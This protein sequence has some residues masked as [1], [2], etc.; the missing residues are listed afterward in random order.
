MPDFEDHY[1]ASKGVQTRYWSVGKGGIPIVLL[2]GL[3]G[4]I[5]DWSETL[6]H[7]SMTRRV[8]AIDLLGS[9]KTDKS[10]TDTYTPDVMRDHVLS[11]L[12]ALSLD[13]VDI[14]GWSLGGRI[15]IDVAHAAPHRL[16][17]L[18]LTAPAGIGADTMID[19][20]A[21]L[22]VILGQAITRP[23]ASSVRIIGNAI[24]S[25]SARRLMKFTARRL[26]LFSDPTSRHAFMGQLKSFVGP[27]GFLPGPRRD[28]L[29]KLPLI[30]T[31]TLAAWGR[32]DNFSPF[33]HSAALLDLMP[34]CKLNVVE[35]CGHTPQIEWPQIYNA[36]V[37]KFVS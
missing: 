2:H 15:A 20:N 25:G 34:H 12:D 33:N 32:N 4:T 35:R 16:R 31:P 29:A 3:G 17:R 23:G 21:S 7:F 24:H 9:G 14:N 1:I 36:I 18:I 10:P 19:L 27:H 28:L 22:P 26:A 11:V 37:D 30:Q 8:I 5:E 13:L 6:P